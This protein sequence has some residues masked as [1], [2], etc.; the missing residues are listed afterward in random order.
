MSKLLPAL[1]GGYHI[2]ARLAIDL[3]LIIRLNDS[4]A[5]YAFLINPFLNCLDIG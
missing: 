2:M 4:L 1:F 5:H 3:V